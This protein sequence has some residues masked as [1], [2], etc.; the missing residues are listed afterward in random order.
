MK[1][2]KE[3]GSDSREPKKKKRFDYSLQRANSTHVALLVLIGLYFIYMAYKMLQNTRSGASDMS[4][5]MTLLLMAVMGLAGLAVIG[6][7]AYIWYHIRKKSELSD[8]EAAQLDREM[9]QADLENYGE[10][11]GEYST[12]VSD[13]EEA[14]YSSSGTPSD[15]EPGAD[16]DAD[17]GDG[18]GNRNDL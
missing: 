12:D 5:P 2:E 15:A 4:M 11:V 17:A 3:T 14:Y 10:I 9:A 6:Y 18:E 16:P 1:D 8:E 7:G 13:L